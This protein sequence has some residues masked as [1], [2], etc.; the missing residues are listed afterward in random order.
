MADA[1]RHARL[2]ALFHQAIEVPVEQRAAWLEGLDDDPAGITG[3]L[4]LLLEQDELTGGWLAGPAAQLLYGQSGA[5][6]PRHCG[7][8]ELKGLLGEGGMGAVYRGWRSDLHSEAAIKILRDAWVSPLRRRQFEREQKILARLRHPCIAQLL[9]AGVTGDGTPWIA[10]ELVEGLRLDEFV[11]QRS[12]G[13]DSI[14]ALMSQIA[15]AVHFAHERAILHRDLKPS[16]ILVDANGNPKLLDFGVSTFLAAGGEHRTEPCWLTPGYAA[17]ELLRGEPA[18]VY[19]DVYS[20]GVLL[21]R[22]LDLNPALPARRAR[23]SRQAEA[24]AICAC[25]ANPDPERRYRSA[26]AM[27]RDLERCLRGEPLQARPRRLAY[28]L[29]CF[30]RR[31]R[32][33]AAVTA[34]SLMLAAAMGATFTV[35]LQ[36]SRDQAAAAA[37]RAGRLR[38]LLL[39]L[40]DA[41]DREAGPSR[42]LTVGA[43][44]DRGVREAASL[45]A[46]PATQ[47]ELYATIGRMYAR[48]GKLEEADRTLDLALERIADPSLHAA[49]LLERA[50]LRITQSRLD[51]A[52]STAR[53]ALGRLSDPSD[54]LRTD[55]EEVLATVLLERGKYKEA[56]AALEPL[57]ARR[58][59]PAAPEAW[60]STAAVL[61][62]ACYF[63]GQYDRARDL[64]QQVLRAL[65]GRNGPRHPS[66]AGTL[67]DLGAIDFDQA[68][69][70]EAAQRYRQALSIFEEWYGP[71]HLQTALALTNLG[72][73]L[74][75]Q[76]KVDEAGPVLERALDIRL[77]RLGAWHPAVASVLNDLG[78]IHMA[79]Q[80]WNEAD[81]CYRRME[82]IYRKAR[83]DDHPAVTT[84][85]S[86]QATLRMRRQDYRAAEA[87][88]RT[89][90]ERYRA[91]LSDSH[92]NT[93]IARIL[94]GRSLI[95]QGRC[96][97]A[98]PW[99]K[100]GHDVL[101]SQDGPP[102]SWLRNAREDLAECY[103]AAGDRMSAEHYRSLSAR[104]E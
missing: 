99:T 78:H 41:G 64:Q 7:P 24:A 85:L 40:F 25:A 79:A 20:L 101:A 93:A 32:A 91:A 77:E 23:R 48:L 70:A 51:D 74:V 33:A 75:Y 100:S 8:Y 86:N 11:R 83:G 1:A 44:L 31:H 92:P 66:V 50:R 82:A 95:R 18:G 69:Y 53:L 67:I 59:L 65:Q 81:A 22:L 62:N 102:S 73:A 35:Q 89:V 28:R 98:L 61:A 80:R 57:L 3:E 15:S 12:L 94:L 38:D 55:A 6:P 76:K 16:N 88:Y 96:R 63:A 10:M 42:E 84:A 47:A 52:E 104:R 97:E 5:A 26:D 13:L 36:R 29:G 103:A 46:E 54:S 58:S 14:L 21:S 49:V 87:M 72:R 2:R 90:I 45:Q 43:L 17:P 9:D 71:A 30:L 56:I 60:A 39:S 4:R 27:A 37:Q 68:R 19:S 34:S